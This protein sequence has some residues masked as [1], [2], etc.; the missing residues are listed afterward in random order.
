M[1]TARQKAEARVL[2][3]MITRLA[4]KHAL[5]IGRTIA[6]DMK[7]AAQAF[8]ARGNLADAALAVDKGKGAM[9]KALEASWADGGKAAGTLTAG[10]LK[11]HCKREV[12]AVA[13]TFASAA[14]TYMRANALGRIASIQGT[15]FDDVK[16]I[17]EQGFSEGYAVSKIARN[18]TQAAPSVSRSRATIIARTETHAGAN[19][20]AFEGAA[21]IGVPMRKVWVAVEDDRTREEHSRADGQE[22]DMDG[23]FT[24]GSDSMKFPGDASASPENV[25]NCRCAAIYEAAE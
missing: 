2:D 6:K 23:M 5:N 14:I 16:R 24:V 21:S 20:G 17:V 13:D 18:I 8:E 11:A 9:T 22:I 7:A 3:A 10:K 15:T 25:I 19:V 4:R 1:A 12:K